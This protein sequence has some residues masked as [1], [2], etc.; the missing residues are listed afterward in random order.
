MRVRSG[1]IHAARVSI[2]LPTT[3][4]NRGTT[5]QRFVVAAFMRPVYLSHSQRPRGI[6]ALRVVPPIIP[7]A[8]EIAERVFPC[9]LVQPPGFASLQEFVNTGPGPSRRFNTAGM[10]YGIRHNIVHAG[11]KVARGTHFSVAKAAPDPPTGSMIPQVCVTRRAPVYAA[12]QPANI[13]NAL[14]PQ[15]DVIVIGQDHP[16]ADRGNRAVQRLKQS[17]L[18]RVQLRGPHK[19]I[20]VLKGRCRD[21]V[22]ARP[23]PGMR[24]PVQRETTLA[25]YCDYLSALLR[26]HATVIVHIGLLKV[27]SGRIHAAQQ[28]R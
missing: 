2:P 12:E 21:Q 22:P 13:R 10:S 16:S 11:P 23:E 9:K 28:P 18:Q 6:G 4:M 15:Q 8:S 14:R 24:R 19:L 3:P 17:R 7:P 1:R 25:T 27:R 5:S 20:L 26:C